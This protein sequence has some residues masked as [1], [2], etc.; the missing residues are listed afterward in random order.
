[1]YIKSVYIK[2]FAGKRN[3]SADIGEGLSVVRGDNESGKSTVCAFIKFM[4][5]GFENKA[6]R[7]RYYG[8][9]CGEVSGSMTVSHGGK[10]Y[11]IERSHSESAGAKFAVYDVVT[12]KKCFAG[13]KPNEVFL[14]SVSPDVF[15]HT[16]Y[17]WQGIAGGIEGKSLEEAME[18]MIFSGDENADVERAL[19]RI[20]GARKALLHKN[21]NGGLIYEESVRLAEA[22]ERL[23]E[24]RKNNRELLLF[25][26]TINRCEE[27]IRTNRDEAKKLSE[28][29]NE[30]SRLSGISSISER[31]E[32]IER[33]SRE[34]EE[35]N[36]ALA[37]YEDRYSFDG[38]IPDEN[39]IT[40]L[41]N[42][43]AK[44]DEALA[45]LEEA[46]KELEGLLSALE[47]EE[48][49]AKTAGMIDG[50]GGAAAISGKLAD[51]NAGIGK[52]KTA[53]AIAFTAAAVAVIGAIVS[54][55]RGVSVM[56]LFCT[57]AAAILITAGAVAVSKCGKISK[58]RSGLIGKFGFENADQLGRFLADI[59][60]I[61]AAERINSERVRSLTEKKNALSEKAGELSKKL[62]SKL[63]KWG[64]R[65]VSDAVE[66]AREAVDTLAKCRN[67]AE[68]CRAALDA[69]K[70]TVT[71]EDMSRYR[72]FID[73]GGDVS[74]L[75]DERSSEADR[76]RLRSLD[77]GYER[78]VGE[79]HEAESRLAVLTATAGDPLS[80][81]SEQDALTKRITELKNKHEAYLL[82]YSKLKEASEGIR[83]N[84]APRL[85]SEAGRILGSLTGGRYTDV[86]ISE[87]FDLNY[88][89]DMSTH[90]ISYMSA[91]T[92]DAAYI[93]L[94][95][96]LADM[97]FE[98][99]APMIFDESFALQDD[100][101]LEAV[102]RLLAE[103][104]KSTQIIVFTSHSREIDML[105][106]IG[107]CFNR[108]EIPV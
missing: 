58:Y 103:K 99:G 87:S 34:L 86:T 19:R 79:K 16:T 21:G 108:V 71:E 68:L 107:A 6:E 43:S 52:A 76:Q 94:R 23:D 70:G 61:L 82:A 67:E 56:G 98:D 39:Y 37:S 13:K 30:Y 59:P 85:A 89:A 28:R 48:R 93:A 51:A 63:A 29:I 95:F 3:I 106:R 96:A 100:K 5:F 7:L 14:A 33:M 38:F 54:F 25:E 55:I 74:S 26:E 104:S 90:P 45:E 18:N 2:S 32:K 72:G 77:S 11:R 97:I 66:K 17:V 60:E 78:L 46:E 84:A 31:V 47:K 42:T 4:M 24:C 22:T 102:C 8:W 15:S 10:D 41:I 9:D 20:D 83:L 64:R 53:A 75:P 49:S 62:D 91:G 80:L 44:A 69:L 65:D 40:D 92:R 50:E 88:N 35:K 36:S 57:A 1:M 101:R 27:D 81:K 73:S 12:G 105:D